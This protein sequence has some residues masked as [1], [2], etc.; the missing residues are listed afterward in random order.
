MGGFFLA[1]SLNTTVLTSRDASVSPLLWTRHVGLTVQPQP[2]VTF[3]GT[4]FPRLSQ[5]YFVNEDAPSSPHSIQNL[6]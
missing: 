1:S 3:R 2:R 4:R 6:C 5:H